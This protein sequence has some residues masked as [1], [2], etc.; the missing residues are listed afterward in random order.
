MTA[1]EFEPAEKLA[2]AIEESNAQT[3]LVV[4]N[5]SRKTHVFKVK[6]TTPDR[7]LVKPNHGLIA[8]QSSTN[9]SI[10]IASHSKKRDL[11][12]K[13]LA[14]PLKSGDK[15]LIQS[16]GLENDEVPALE[17]KT[18]PELARLLTNII[19][20][21]EKKDVAQKKIPVEFSFPEPSV[22]SN[23]GGLQTSDHAEAL[24]EKLSRTTSSSAVIPGTPEAMFAENAALRKKYDDLVAFVVDLTSERDQLATQLDEA[25]SSVA[26]APRGTPARP[27]AA[28]AQTNAVNVS[29]LQV[30]I[31]ALVAFAMGHFISKA[32]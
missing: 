16:C 29:M 19:D 25:K 32:R 27:A 26:A 14:G 18:A 10:I 24:K 22:K 30:V 15:F 5:V 9:I 13:G 3:T 17:S 28:V 7:Y 1:L 8:A 21:K 2:I 31:V 11:L 6:T 23:N 4:R 12:A 20:S